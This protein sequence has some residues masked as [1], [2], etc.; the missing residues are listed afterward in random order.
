MIIELI[1]PAK[2]KISLGDTD[3][4]E[5]DITFGRLNY[6]NLQTRQILRALLQDAGRVTGFN[7]SAGRLLIEIF[8]ASGGGCV[9]YFTK[10]DEKSPRRLK[11]LR[12]PN[13]P[14]LCRVCRFE[15]PDHLLAVMERLKAWSGVPVEQCALFLLDGKYY[16]SVSATGHNSDHV[17]ATLGEFGHFDGHS[18][19]EAFYAEHGR[20]VEG[21]TV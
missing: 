7:Y 19:S 17:W 14:K 3:M 18:Q 9:I 15:N 1:D 10:L 13:K 12:P 6:E 16:L 2:L 20:K 8:P 5:L 4:R 21:F 11:R